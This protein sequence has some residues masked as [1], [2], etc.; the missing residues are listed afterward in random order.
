MRVRVRFTKIGKVRFLGN[1]DLARNWERAIRRADLPVAYTEGFSP[2]PKLHYGLALPTGAE[3]C[4]EYMDIDLSADVPLEGLAE[5]LSEGMPPGIDVTSVGEVPSNA[6]ALQAVVDHCTWELDFVGTPVA[7]L[8]AAAAKL[9]A[10][11]EVLLT[12]ERKKKSITENVRP[13]LLDL[14]VVERHEGAATLAATLA[15]KPRSIRPSEL[16]TCLGVDS[17]STRVRRIEQWMTHD[18]VAI[19]PILAGSEAVR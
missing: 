6:T 4:A 16:L 14:S 7:D 2:R 1:L 19:P 12:F 18:G 10:A 11:D 9:M 13:A 15:T 8:E 17:D 3:S 5:A